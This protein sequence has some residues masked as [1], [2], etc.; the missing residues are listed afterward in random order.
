MC[1]LKN[2][3]YTI[4]KY[5]IDILKK[6]NYIYVKIN[7]LNSLKKIYNLFQHNIIPKINESK[8]IVL[9]LI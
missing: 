8:S 9:S 3:N 1:N 6:H 5:I 7:D 4:E 2:H